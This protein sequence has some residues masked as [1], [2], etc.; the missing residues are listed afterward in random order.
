[1]IAITT[2]VAE[3]FLLCQLLTKRYRDLCYP[4]TLVTLPSRTWKTFFLCSQTFLFTYLKGVFP[5]SRDG[6]NMEVL[7]YLG[8]V[9]MSHNII[10]FA[11]FWHISFVRIYRVKR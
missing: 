9:F 5:P 2:M 6:E 7:I 10:L 1:M 3:F 11:I 4:R 8:K